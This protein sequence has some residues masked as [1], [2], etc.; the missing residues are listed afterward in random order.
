M[1][2]PPAQKKAKLLPRTVESD[3]VS[4]WA[5]SPHPGESNVSYQNRRAKQKEAIDEAMR[6]LK[7]ANQFKSGAVGWDKKLAALMKNDEIGTSHLFG[8]E[9]FK[10]ILEAFGPLVIEGG[11]VAMVNEGGCSCK[12]LWSVFEQILSANVALLAKDV[13]ES[14]AFPAL[15]AHLFLCKQIGGIFNTFIREIPHGIYQE[16]PHRRD[17]KDLDGKID[18]HAAMV[19]KQ[20][21]R[22]QCTQKEEE[23]VSFGVTLPEGY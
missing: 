13:I 3:K 9:E 23:L 18:E 2:S 10:V 21:I 19:S 1:S 4:F 20:L 17:M 7:H 16:M 8:V 22:K 6:V 12:A 11:K 14:E 15:V 5:I